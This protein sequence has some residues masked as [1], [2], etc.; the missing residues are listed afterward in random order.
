M[1]ITL[2]CCCCI[3]DFSLG[4]GAIC[5]RHAAQFELRFPRRSSEYPWAQKEVL[6]YNEVTYDYRVSEIGDAFFVQ[7][8]SSLF[9]VVINTFVFRIVGVAKLGQ[10]DE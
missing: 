5:V 8:V 1:V 9:D 3:N 2:G 7:V 6:I 4:H 10:V